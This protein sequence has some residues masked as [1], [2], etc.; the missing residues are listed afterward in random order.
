MKNIEWAF[1]LV[2]CLLLISMPP[3]LAVL[4]WA[5][6]SLVYPDFPSFPYVLV[7]WFCICLVAMLLP[8]FFSKWAGMVLE[9]FE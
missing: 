6:G 3:I 1:G 9:P 7:S 2:A 4:T 5:I 8:P